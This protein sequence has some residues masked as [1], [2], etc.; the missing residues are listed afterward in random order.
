MRRHDLVLNRNHNFN[1]IL[2]LE[3][4]RKIGSKIT[5]KITIKKTPTAPE[6]IHAV[7]FS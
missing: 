4:N 2:S 7:T 1:L 5:I 3:I 6:L